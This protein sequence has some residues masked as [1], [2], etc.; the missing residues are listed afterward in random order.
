VTCRRE[1]VSSAGRNGRPPGREAIYR[2]SPQHS[3]CPAMKLGD[4]KKQGARDHATARSL[5]AQRSNPDVRAAGPAARSPQRL[6]APRDAAVGFHRS[7]G[8]PK[9]DGGLGRIRLAATRPSQLRRG[10]SRAPSMRHPLRRPHCTRLASEQSGSAAGLFSRLAA[11]A[12]GHFRRIG[13]QKI[14]LEPRRQ[15]HCCLKRT[16]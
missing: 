9:A 13:P 14:F 10:A 3:L 8:R 7:A 12:T 16:R 1:L 15:S 11:A 5:R 6:S 2:T 4:R